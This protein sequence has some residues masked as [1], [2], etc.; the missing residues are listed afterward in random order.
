MYKLLGWFL[1][2]APVSVAVGQNP[3]EWKEFVNKP[4]G[5]QV[6]LPGTPQ[7]HQQSVN[8]SVGKVYVVLTVA[9]LKKGGDA[10]VVG[11]SVLPDSAVKE[12]EERR[13]D[14]ARDG[15][16]SS[17][18]GKLRSEKALKLGGHPGRELLIDVDGK[19][20]VRAQLYAVKNQ[21][22]Q[23]MAVG[24]PAL[25]G[26]ADTDKFFKSFKLLK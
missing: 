9:E 3:G 10:Y 12:T 16:V 20:E 2:L 23:V 6:L 4:G 14:H 11:V 18:K 21:L 5:F 26:S 7:E 19:T 22:Y 15:A 17:V 8:T 13:L 1:L 24:S 25:V